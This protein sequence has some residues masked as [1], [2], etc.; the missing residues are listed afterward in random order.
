MLKKISYILLF[1]LI[2]GLVPVSALANTAEIDFS[3][4]DNQN[5]NFDAIEYLQGEDILQGYPD[6]TFKP[7]NRINRAEFTKILV[8]NSFSEQEIND[9]N[10]SQLADLSDVDQ[11]AWYAP[12]VCKA[13]TE[14]IIA[15]YPD[16]TFRPADFINLAEASKIISETLDLE[17][18]TLST[19]QWF[20]PHVRSLSAA[21]SIP[22]TIDAAENDITRGEMSEMIY[23]LDANITDKPTQNLENL[24][25]Q[26]GN[27]TSCDA[28]KERFDFHNYYPYYGF[29]NEIAIP[30]ALELD[31]GAD[32]PVSAAPTSNSVKAG[33][34][35]EDFS[36]TNIQVKGVD[37]PDVVKN[38][39]T[40]IY[41]INQDYSSPRVQVVSA[42]S[43]GD[44]DLLSSVHFNQGSPEGLFLNGDQLIV[45]TNESYFYAL[46]LEGEEARPADLEILNA[47]QSISEETSDDLSIEPV[48][49]MFPTYPTEKPKMGVF[50]F[51]VSDPENIKFERKVK[52]EGYYQNAR[53]VDGQLYV[54]SNYSPN[55]WSLGEEFTGEELLPQVQYGNSE[56]ED[57]LECTDV[58][59]LPNHEDLNFLLVTSLD[60]K[61]LGSRANHEVLLASSTNMFMSKDNLYLTQ[62]RYNYRAF[63]DFIIE[64]EGVETSIYKFNLEESGPSFQAIGNVKGSELNQFSMNEK[65]G[66][67][68]IATTSG[69]LWN[70]SSKNHLFSFDSNMNQI[71]SVEDIAPGEKIYSARFIGNRA[72]MVT[73][74]KVD[75]LYVIDISDSKNLEILGELKIPGYS[76]YLHPYD[77]NLL[78]G[79]GK[80]A[81]E[82]DGL[83]QGM[84]VSLFDVS[85]PTNPTQK[86]T[87]SIGSRGTESELL[88]NHKAL[89][90]SKEKNIIAFP[91]SI[92]EREDSSM[93]SREWGELSFVGALNLGLD[94]NKQFQLQ[95]KF[96]HLKE[97]IDP[98]NPWNYDHNSKINRMIYIG[99]TMFSISNNFVKSHSLDNQEV[100]DSIKLR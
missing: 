39:G 16:G 74:R 20:A 19:D 83:F 2:Q 18:E 30:E 9:C 85:D 79:F 25:G 65:D 92:Y 66:D 10:V 87:Y 33:G 94:E 96:S 15:G 8:A 26:L 78:L 56:A 47:E 43:N 48:S 52:V 3:D 80:D 37:E 71:G 73:F 27:I 84:K 68:F 21:N 90:F 53:L 57:I 60:T 88:Y 54:I 7:R 28:L 46:P 77:E 91:V 64:D 12:F 14:G 29:F 93:S 75:P 1:A 81:T 72:Y 97:E 44:L 23:R 63:D 86:D 98:E 62:P 13:F 41:S 67:F 61:D 69:D 34:A 51:D 70:S 89:L 58:K 76:D 31:A 4:L 49:S 35:G 6:G 95:D 24:T 11:S 45:I 100:L 59:Y 82:E 5:L 17:G 50:M 42:N 22:S 40:H 99:D 55:T 32:I 36:T 38:N